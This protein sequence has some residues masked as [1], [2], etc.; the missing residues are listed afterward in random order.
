MWPEDWRGEMGRALAM[1]R[2]W[3]LLLCEMR[4]H[5]I[6]CVQKTDRVKGKSKEAVTQAR[7]N[8]SCTRGIE[9]GRSS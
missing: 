2:T 8:G 9:V 1:G 6:C 5:L 3:D 7:D 4:D